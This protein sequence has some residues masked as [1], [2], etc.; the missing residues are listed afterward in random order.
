MKKIKRQTCGMMVEIMRKK[1][2][3]DRKKTQKS[4]FLLC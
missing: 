4:L 3:L 1:T 2:N